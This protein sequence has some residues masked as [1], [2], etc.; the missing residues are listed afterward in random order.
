M[1]R[2][3]ISPNEP[4]Y[5]SLPPVTKYRLNENTGQSEPYTFYSQAPIANSARIVQ[6]VPTQS[7]QF[8]VASPLFWVAAAATVKPETHYYNTAT[9]TI[10]A[11]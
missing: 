9:Q 3:L 4:V 1:A 8:Q 10:V 6:V 2:A 7:D 11:L 5:T